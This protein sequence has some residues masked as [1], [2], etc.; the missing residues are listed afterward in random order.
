EEEVKEEEVLVECRV[1]F[2]SFMGVGRDVHCFAF[3]MDGGGRQHY[4]CH[5]FWCD[6]DAGRLSEAVQA[7]CMLRYQ[8][9]LLA[10]PPSQRPLP[11][12][13]R[14]S[15]PLGSGGGNGGAGGGTASRRVSSS[16]NRGLL[17]LIDTLKQKGPLPAAADPP[18]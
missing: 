11:S 2:L 9:C 14:G 4:E 3:I 12:C 6:P 15:S 8:K 7:A 5:V 10:H 16:V 18:E 1:R 13:G 17:S